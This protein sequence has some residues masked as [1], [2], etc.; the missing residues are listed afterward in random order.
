MSQATRMRS[1]PT[2]SINPRAFPGPSVR[3][4]EGGNRAA[5]GC[6]GIEMT[7]NC[8][9]GAGRLVAYT[10]FTLIVVVDPG[11][12][13]I[14]TS[15]DHHSSDAT[16]VRFLHPSTGELLLASGDTNGN[17]IVWDVVDGTP[18]TAMPIQQDSVKVDAKILSIR[19]VKIPKVSSDTSISRGMC[20]QIDQP[21]RLLCLT[22]KIISLVDASSQTL[23]WR[24]DLGVPHPLVGMSLS[25]RGDCI[26]MNVASE[27]RVLSRIG[28]QE[29]CFSVQSISVGS[30]GEL[31]Q[32]IH[33]P[34]VQNQVYLVFRTEVLLYDI[35]IK[36]PI[37]TFQLTAG[38]SEFR[39]L[40]LAP[41]AEANAISV[42]LGL[43]G[44][45]P[46]YTI[47]EDGSVNAWIR[48]SAGDAFSPSPVDLRTSRQGYSGRPF[49]MS[50]ER[51]SGASLS[52]GTEGC[53]SRF[54]VVTNDGTMTTWMHGIDGWSVS[55]TIASTGNQISHMAIMHLAV[56]SCE[57]D[58]G[59]GRP[60]CL[61]L[62][63]TTGYL[64]VLDILTGSLICKLE[65]MSDSGVT[66]CS[67]KALS[68]T[69]ILVGGT[70]QID[71]QYCN[72]LL[73]VFLPSLRID[74]Y[75]GRDLEPYK[76]TSVEVSCRK[77]LLAVCHTGG[78]CEIWD[79]PGRWLLQKLV[80]QFTLV[81]WMP[82]ILG[83]QGKDPEQA[84]E[85]CI[86]L[87]PDGLMSFF[88]VKGG[89]V[90]H[91]RD[92]PS[93]MHTKNKIIVGFGY[94]VVKADWYDDLLL[95]GDSVG[96]LCLVNLKTAKFSHIDNQQKTTVKQLSICPSK[97]VESGGKRK[98]VVCLAL[99]LFA[100][101]EFGIW[102]I[103]QRQRLSYSRGPDQKTRALRAVSIGW[104]PGPFPI[105]ATPTGTI[106]ILDL[107]LG[108]SCASVALRSL[109]RPLRTTSFLMRPHAAFLNACLMNGVVDPDKWSQQQPQS[110][111]ATDQQ[112]AEPTSVKPPYRTAYGELVLKKINC[113]TQEALLHLQLV[114]KLVRDAISEL[115]SEEEDSA[116]IMKRCLITAAVFADEQKMQF[117]RSAA[118]A[119]KSAKGSGR[120]RFVH[121]TIAMKDSASVLPSTPSRPDAPHEPPASETATSTK[122]TSPA[123]FASVPDEIESGDWIG[124]DDENFIDDGLLHSVDFMSTSAK[125]RIA[126]SSKATDQYS[127]IAQQHVKL[128]AMNPAVQLLL[129]TPQGSPEWQANLYKACVVAGG[130]SRLHYEHTIKRVS[131]MLI[132]NGNI[133]GAV[134]MLCLVG[135]G[136]EACRA[137]Q[138][139]DRW[140]DAARLAKVSLSEEETKDILR[141]WASH[142]CDCGEYLNAACVLVTIKDF[143]RALT[144][145]EPLAEFCDIAALLALACQKAGIMSYD[146]PLAK[147]IYSQY[148]DFLH[149]ISA[150]DLAEKYASLA[151]TVTEV[152]PEGNK[153]P[154]LN[155]LFGS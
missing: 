41:S 121:P 34:S 14:V 60:N 98:A 61:V 53:Y 120:S 79:V 140:E 68:P 133:E 30:L 75:K 90:K 63:T 40:M 32:V 125:E 95:T 39:G 152:A 66:I 43:S 84:G 1:L 17:V 93:F 64:L 110:D 51:V 21:I 124:A 135:R 123:V 112:V 56:T 55:G 69:M 139:H 108:S 3:P 134:E 46:V 82:G 71:D 137:Y 70:K 129:D 87:S 26:V 126:R 149:S 16:C 24:C 92:N 47:H 146:D 136:H 132:G 83:N 114:S 67:L 20:D 100:D 11:S 44:P 23:M 22:P 80:E 54:A 49:V 57:T 151:N 25:S 72:A 81:T 52:M 88:R 37:D 153:A 33:C 65:V 89:Q 58:L 4:G 42:I 12:C 77:L 122:D 9:W 36:K 48:H 15:L 13:Q 96:M 109:A 143:T 19:H 78:V 5:G 104:V 7:E 106:M 76:M 117:W 2:V 27:L 144:V 107:S 38:R 127:A 154:D 101:E 35:S 85:T 91:Y 45:A 74:E 142:L 130:V 102:D 18:I 86:W 148:S 128:G 50:C 113:H 31:Q 73:S 138:T 8:D 111:G 119:L 105:I 115:S 141:R 28:S 131:S 59:H 10:H 99:V 6:S 150:P 29:A 155:E 94:P 62:M 118:I 103:G 147:R 145:L 116:D 97:Y